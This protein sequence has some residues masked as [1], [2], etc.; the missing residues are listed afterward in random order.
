MK[1]KPYIDL[2]LDEHTGESQITTRVE[3]FIEMIR[4]KKYH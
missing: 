2:T 3:S 4:R 1:N